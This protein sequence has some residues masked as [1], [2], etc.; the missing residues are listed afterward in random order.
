MVRAALETVELGTPGDP[1]VHLKFSP[2]PILRTMR[3]QRTIA[4]YEIRRLL[5]RGGMGELF[6]GYHPDLERQVAIKLLRNDI[7]PDHMR[8]RFLREARAV[9]RLRHPNIVTL[10][11]YGVHQGQQYLVMEYLPGETLGDMIER[12]APLSLPE[13]LQLIESVCAGLAYAHAA[14][15]VHRDIKPANLMVDADGTLKILDFG[16]ARMPAT[17]LTQEDAIIGTLNYMSPE[18]LTTGRVDH[19][20]DIFSVG[21]VLY[22]IACYKQ[23]FPGAVSDGVMA[24]IMHVDP[25]PLTKVCGGIDPAISLI[26]AKALQKDPDLRYQNLTELQA[27]LAHVRERLCAPAAHTD[28]PV[29]VVQRPA[30]VGDWTIRT[31]QTTIR[32]K[33]RAVS[34]RRRIVIAAAFAA[35]AAAA[36][37]TVA[38]APMM[39]RPRTEASGAV[40]PPADVPIG[41]IVLRW[42]A[43]LPRPVASRMPPPRAVENVEP[44]PKVAKAKP[45]QA[46]PAATRDAVRRRDELKPPES[47]R[48]QTALPARGAPRWLTPL[49]SSARSEQPGEPEPAPAPAP[50]PAAAP[51]PVPAPALPIAAAPPQPPPARPVEDPGVRDRLQVQNVFDAY[52]KAMSAR[53]ID[54]VAKVLSLSPRQ[55]DS[56]R[57]SFENMQSQ[58]ISIVAGP[59]IRVDARVATVEATLRYDVHLGTGERRRSDVK[60]VLTF[61]KTGDAWRI[62]RVQ[63]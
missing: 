59:A 5:K 39:M 9:A 49:R 20:S 16:L 13:R 15:I 18:Q 47:E 42:W 38:L 12:R 62:V 60:T 3:E 23:A 17:T 19:R 10:F 32:V 28:V 44:D 45:S 46:I 1:Y 22:E 35:A 37:G 53:Q 58:F 61:E 29:G 55:H 36:A 54:E 26:A 31:G 4:K 7:D 24:R 2:R 48:P 21:A 27:D 41:S 33:P 43:P 51:T 57:R 11:D 52:L 6:L 25:P 56:L 63:Q 40:G 30:R 14:R 34:T 50:P 8:E